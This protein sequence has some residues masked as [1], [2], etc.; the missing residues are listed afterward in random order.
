MRLE[1]ELIL[2]LSR[3]LKGGIVKKSSAGSCGV[4]VDFHL[5]SA[6]VEKK[7]SAGSWD[8]TET[9]ATLYKSTNR[10]EYEQ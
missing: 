7:L 3:R 2:E 5:P 4:S 9:A 8:K 1:G 6:Y 10:D